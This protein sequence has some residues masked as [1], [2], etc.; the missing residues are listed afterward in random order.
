MPSRIAM[1]ESGANAM[2]GLVGNS[3]GPSRLKLIVC[4]RLAAGKAIIEPAS[5]ASNIRR[6]IPPR[7]TGAA[8]IVRFCSISRQS[9]LECACEITRLFARLLY[10]QGFRRLLPVEFFPAAKQFDVFNLAWLC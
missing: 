4:R 5:T 7:F 1:S 2:P 8:A 3:P 6:Q 9:D 10:R